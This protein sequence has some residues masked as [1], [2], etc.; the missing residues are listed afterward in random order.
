[1]IN[2][3]ARS[4]QHALLG[5]VLL[6]SHFCYVQMTLSHVMAVSRNWVVKKSALMLFNMQCT[7]K[8]PA[9]VGIQIY[10]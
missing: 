7:V 1:M 10:S 3:Y 8:N 6:F 5:I 9:T 2:K 4:M